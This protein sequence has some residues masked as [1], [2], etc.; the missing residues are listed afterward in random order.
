MKWARWIRA[1]WANAANVTRKIEELYPSIQ[2]WSGF[3]WSGVVVAG[4]EENIIYRC[5]DGLLLIA[6]VKEGYDHVAHYTL[7][8]CCKESIGM[9][10]C[11]CLRRR[12]GGSRVMITEHIVGEC[13]YSIYE[14]TP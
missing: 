9:D 8:K 10:N 2:T 1:G 5:F 14:G 7:R 6:K 13:P 12:T 4:N 11:V 3:F